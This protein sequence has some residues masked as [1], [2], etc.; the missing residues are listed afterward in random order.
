MNPDWS[1]LDSSAPVAPLVG[2]FVRS[3][4]LSLL[5]RHH[6]PPESVPHIVGRQAGAVA[7][8][9]SDAGL[10]LL[11]PRDLVDYRSPVGDV[12]PVLVEMFE[13]TDS[14]T[15][16]SLD[17]LPLEAVEVFGRAFASIGFDAEPKEN[18][19][20]AVLQ[21]PSTFD[22]YMAAIGK[23]ERHEIRRKGRRLSEELGDLSVESFD[24]PGPPLDH[25][26]RFHRQATG[27]KGTF[28]T[29]QMM[30]FF[31]ALLGLPGW[32]LATLRGGEG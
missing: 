25:F 3:P 21:L 26:F 19:S 30:A 29:P 15:A 6:G 28:M 22:D 5:E 10:A 2:P 18:E 24:S 31:T 32:Q 13:A 7:F 20:A 14:G 9:R 11:G 4:F 12:G 23:K 17:S 8:E 16:I 1:L 27:D